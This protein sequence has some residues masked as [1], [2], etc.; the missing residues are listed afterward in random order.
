MATTEILSQV[1]VEARE[2]YVESTPTGIELED[3]HS[4]D[5]R[6][7]DDPDPWD[8]DKIRIH[9]K[10]YSLSQVVEM[11][12]VGDIDLAPDFQR[13][14]VWKPPQ[15][16]ALIES[17]LLGIPLPSFYFN[18]DDE[19]KLQVIDG[20]QRLTTIYGFVNNEFKLGKMTYLHDLKGQGFDD[21]SKPF[22]RRLKGA[23]FVAHVI[24]PQTPYRVKFDIFR[25]INT[26][27]TRLSAQEIRHCMSAAQSRDFLAKLV[28]D[29]SFKIATGGVLN[30]HPRMADR[31][32]A[33]R[34]IA[35]RLSDPDDY[36]K[37]GSL[38]EFLGCVTKQ[39]DDMDKH[40][41]EGHLRVFVQ[42]M[43][44]CHA[45]F[46][47]YAF[48]KWPEGSE[49][50]NPIN[51]ALF[52]TWGTVLAGYEEGNIR[53]SARDLARRAR[54][55]M[56]SDADFIDSIS[57]TTGDVSRVRTRFAKVRGVV[58]ELVR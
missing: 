47:E 15:R 42:G 6:V 18:E 36:A 16:W 58:R 54:E 24:D 51:R 26:G 32:V 40:E 29:E 55:M 44:N 7:P 3:D 14:F 5:T 34:F 39:L 53:K 33:L 45:V 10:H 38:D 49:R 43:R 11:T 30:K 50:K 56:T 4:A 9:T 22:Q 52:E 21:L 2:E 19:G 27:G 48:R 31:E 20:V 17:L 35:F 12:E 41:L 13:E 28:N 57:S 8:P 23:Q 46:G 1:K 37:H 25:R